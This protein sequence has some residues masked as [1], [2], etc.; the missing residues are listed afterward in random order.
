MLLLARKCGEAVVISENIEVRVVSVRGNQV[1]LQFDA[2]KEIK[3][4][5]EELLGDA[6][7]DVS[8]KKK[9]GKRWIRFFGE[10]AANQNKRTL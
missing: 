3:I 1:R 8:Q 7:N 6:R 5:R 2:P 10:P 9:H 4:M